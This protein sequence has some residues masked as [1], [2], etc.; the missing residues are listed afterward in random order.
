METDGTYQLTAK[1]LDLFKNMYLCL[2]PWLLADCSGCSYCQR[3]A[4][5]SLSGSAI[6]KS[7]IITTTVAPLTFTLKVKVL[8]FPFALHFLKFI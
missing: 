6:V 4:S 8:G 5:Y 7:A 3:R 2:L 1:I